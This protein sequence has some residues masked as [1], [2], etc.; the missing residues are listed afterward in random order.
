[1]E[2]HIFL[3]CDK[4]HLKSFAL[5]FPSGAGAP[6]VFFLENKIGQLFSVSYGF[7]LQHLYNLF[8]YFKL[9][10]WV[11]WTFS[12]EKETSQVSLKTC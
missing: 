5:Y 2:F 11:T 6:I 9:V 8:G 4:I 7:M 3:F 12:G 1:M 10:I